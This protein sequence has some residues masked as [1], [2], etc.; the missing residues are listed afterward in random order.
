MRFAVA[1]CLALLLALPARA[2]W[3]ERPVTAIVP[4]AAGGGT[5]GV[6]RILAEQLGRALGQ[7]VVIENRGGANGTIGAQAAARA[8]PDGYTIFLTTGTT[9][10]ISPALYRS[11]PYDPQRDFVPVARIGQFPLMLA[12]HPAVPAADLPA[13]LALARTQPQSLSFGHW[14]AVYLAAGKT[15]MRQI[16][17]EVLDVPYRSSAATMTDLVAGRIG[18]AI[19]DLTVGIPLSRNGEVR[20]LAVT[21]AAR[22]ALLPSLPTLQEAGLAGYDFAAWMAAYAPTGTPE[23][24]VQGAGAAIRRVLADPALVARLADLGFE[25]VQGD[26]AELAAFTAAERAKWKEIVAASNIT[27]E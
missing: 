23:E 16:G 19:V 6:A 22:S 2:A 26:A 20:A 27:V 13:F 12:V 14:S 1:C 11:L 21:G 10:A 8:R 25:T 24:A 4:F 7:P 18:F 9:Q 17:A 5:D 3:P 15:L